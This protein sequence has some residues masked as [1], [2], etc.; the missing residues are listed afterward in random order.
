MAS[1][2][3][4]RVYLYW[5]GPAVDGIPDRV[6]AGL[7]TG[8]FF[9]GAITGTGDM[10]GDGYNDVYA[11]APWFVAVGAHVTRV[12]RGYLFFGG[13]GTGSI[14]DVVTEARPI[15][16]VTD[17]L[18]F[19]NSVAA[20]GDVNGD[21]FAD[22]LVGQP[23]DGHFVAGRAYIFYGG[24]PVHRFPDIVLV[25]LFRNL[26]SFFL[27]QMV[28]FESYY[29]VYYGKRR[30]GGLFYHRKNSPDF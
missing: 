15:G 17:Q 27:F 13:T 16:G 10:N 29:I 12:G 18:Q 6:L 24:V 8:E 1:R 25:F 4:G 21:G 2:N 30:F 23:A 19:T 11:G 28:L 26:M 22:V 7:R 20:A 14:V 3:S 5:G 9:G